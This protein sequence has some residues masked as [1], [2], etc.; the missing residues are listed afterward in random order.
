MSYTVP[1]FTAPRSDLENAAELA[2]AGYLEQNADLE[3]H[4]EITDHLNGLTPVISQLAANVGLPEDAL[5]VRVGGHANPDHA[6][7]EGWAPEMLSV[8]IHVNQGFRATGSADEAKD[9]EAQD[10]DDAS[11]DAGASAYENLGSPPPENPGDPTEATQAAE[12]AERALD[13]A[14]DVSYEDDPNNPEL[15][16][17]VPP[18]A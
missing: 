7:R 14:E 18:S 1:V 15:P 12:A 10:L 5:D 11:T 2:F 3:C 4:D 17:S 16:P 8:S 6:P 9:D 13:D